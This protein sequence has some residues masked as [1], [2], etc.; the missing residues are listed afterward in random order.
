[1]ARGTKS[2]TGGSGRQKGRLSHMSDIT[3]QTVPPEFQGAA[4][5]LQEFTNIEAAIR[6]D[7][8]RLP[9]LVETCRAAEQDLADV[10]IAAAGI[11]AGKDTGAIKKARGTLESSKQA[12]VAASDRLNRWR[13][14]AVSLAPSLAEAHQEACE[15]MPKFRARLTEAFRPTYEAAAEAWMKAQSERRALEFAV[16]SLPLREPEAVPMEIPPGFE[17]PATIMKDLEAHLGKIAKDAKAAGDTAVLPGEPAL[18]TIDP[19]APYVLKHDAGGLPAG[20]V[21][22]EATFSPNRLRRYIHIGWAVPA[23]PAAMSKARRAAE[24]ALRRIEAGRQAEAEGA[25]REE[26]ARLMREQDLEFHKRDPIG[27]RH[28]HQEREAKAA[29]KPP[30]KTEIIPATMFPDNP[31]KRA[32]YARAA[33]M[34]P[35]TKPSLIEEI[36]KAANEV[37]AAF[38]ERP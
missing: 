25:S 7:V 11:D 15:A 16:G 22:V 21:V 4:Q 32:L 37:D 36:D 5:T 3:T 24:G 31:E 20:S 28:Y 23:T 17:I 29:E 13:M 35:P 12:L 33:H 8:D 38:R 34:Y 27:W 10:E 9:E 2:F 18:P 6:T 26:H 30:A 19:C 14:K 1:M